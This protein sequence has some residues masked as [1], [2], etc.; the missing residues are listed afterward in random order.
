[1]QDATPRPSEVF[2]GRIYR[3]R[4]TIWVLFAYVLLTV[5]MTWPLAARLGTHLAGGG[6][7]WAHQWTF[8]WVKRSILEGHSPFYTDLLFYPQGVSLTYHNFAWLNIAVWLPL[9]AI[10]GRVIAY[11]V[12]FITVFALNGFAMYLLAREVT[13]SKP[14]AFIGGL[15]YGFWPYTLSHYEHPNLI[16]TCWVPL[17]LLYLRRTLQGGQKRDALLAAFFL[18]LTGLTRWHLLIMGGVIIGLYLLYQCLVDKACRTRRTLGLL[19]LI[20]LVTGILLTPL[21]AP[22]VIAQLTRLHPEDIFIDE[23]T[24]AQTDLLAYVLPR[25]YHPLWGDAVSPL[26]ENFNVNKIYVAFLGYTIIALALY[27]ATRNWRQA[28]FWILAAVVYIALALGPQLRVSGQLYPQVPMPYRLVGDLFFIRI[29]RKPDRFNIF[30]GLPI[31]MLTSLGVRALLH[32]RPFDLKSAL[33]VGVAG[34][35]VLGEYCSVPYPTE[36]PFTPAW[37]SQL[38]QEPGDFAILDLPTHGHTFDKH[39]MFYQTTHGKPLVEGKTARPPREALAFINSV[40]FLKYVRQHNAMDPALVDVSHQL[41]PLAE[42]GIRYIILHKKFAG[43]NQL[44]TWQDWLTFEPYHEDA[45]VVVYRTDPH[46]ERDFVLAHNMTD[47]IGLIRATSTP[48]GTT[49]A[50]LIQADV[51]W[52]SAAAPGRD[53]DVCLN[54]INTAGKAAQ[55][56]CELLSPTWP[57]SRWEAGEVVRG[58][59]A[60]QVSPFLEPGTYSLTLT[61]TDSAPAGHPF[62]LGSLRVDPLPRVFV[63]PR[64]AHRLHVLWGDVVLLRGYDLQLSAEALDL[65]LYWQAMC[66]MERDYKVFVHLSS[67]NDGTLVAQDDSVPRRWTYPT[68]WWEKDEI[69]TDTITL[70]VSG[71]SAGRYE[72]AVGICDSGT[73]ERLPVVDQTGASLPEQKLVL[74][75]ITVKTQ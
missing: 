62:V 29:L 2:L 25:R 3:Q 60:L 75:D 14:A 49:Q 11:N 12:I 7:L 37:Y 10:V 61:L 71:L 65:T 38:A 70:D 30:L 18:F 69:I 26:Y 23:Q 48:T 16:A 32:Q 44:A 28:R 68:S 51:R 20:V 36:P 52:G 66:R 63:E 34:T 72:V 58:A 24:T 35:L 39:Y 22:L 33:L 47:E 54:L 53:Y 73:L 43:P 74:P 4:E 55:S 21:A 8:W 17:V 57:T 13:G 1:M 50:G 41:R 15:V 40:P 5:V 67:L 64:P 46:P 59:Y 9:Q 19:V 31:G 27:G 56:H 45:D 42:A 6:D